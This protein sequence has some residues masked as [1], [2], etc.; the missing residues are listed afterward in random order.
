MHF[1]CAPPGRAPIAL[2]CKRWRAVCFAEPALWQKLHIV[3]PQGLFPNGAASEAAWLFGK[4]W[5]I[6][7]CGGL[8]NELRLSTLHH[9]GTPR[10]VPD[11]LL[12]QLLGEAPSS[13]QALTLDHSR[14]LPP[15]VMDLL[16]Q[17]F[18]ALQR[19]A[20]FGAS[21]PPC[22][23]AA[24]AQLPLASL[25]LQLDKAP[26]ARFKATLAALSGTLT[27]LQLQCHASVR[28]PALTSLPFLEEC[29][30]T[31]PGVAFQVRVRQGCWQH[32]LAGFCFGGPAATW[33][34]AS[35]AAVKQGHAAVYTRVT[36]SAAP[37]RALGLE[38]ARGAPL[39]QLLAHMQRPAARPLQRLVLVRQ[40]V[41]AAELAACAPALSG[42]LE[43]SLQGCSGMP[44]AL[45]QLLPMV[46]GL[47]ALAIGEP[48][49]AQR[50]RSQLPSAVLAHTG[51]RSLSATCLDMTA[52]LPA[53]PVMAGGGCLVLPAAGQGGISDCCRHHA[54][55]QMPSLPD[56][57][58]RPPVPACAVLRL[59]TAARSGSAA[60]RGP[61]KPEPEQQPRAAS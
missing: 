48:F 4:Q 12:E 32:V 45:E 23:P 56:A 5:L 49:F 43:L 1:V 47:T 20:M 52:G 54:L 31:A 9:P 24:L 25:T 15:G 46:P 2:V 22:A 34:P 51:L 58:R 41:P 40:A 10:S 38:G 30:L 37:L 7:R 57:V 61:H 50:E 27:A 44:A 53:A 60:G 29:Q 14:V 6:R 13:L 28:L 18:S 17:R 55:K 42:L 8:V 59:A 35:H 16:P 19:L 11:R 33:P 21:L 26:P 3:L 36:M 39:P